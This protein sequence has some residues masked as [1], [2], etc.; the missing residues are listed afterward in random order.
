MSGWAISLV[1]IAVI[2][3]ISVFTIICFMIFKMRATQKIAR[4]KIEKFEIKQ[5]EDGFIGLTAAF[6]QIKNE[7]KI[8]GH[9][10]HFSLKILQLIQ[11]KLINYRGLINAFD[12]DMP[13]AI[14]EF[15]QEIEHFIDS[16]SQT[17]S[18]K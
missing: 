10:S 2:A 14:D 7:Y 12:S 1:V 9:L 6:I 15:Q 18:N 13:F 17:K 5:T 16:M 8:W 11:N 4:G 3:F